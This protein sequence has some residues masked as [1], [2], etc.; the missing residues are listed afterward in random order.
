MKPTRN[1][2]WLVSI[3]MAISGTQIGGTYHIFLAYSL[4]RCND[5]GIPI[6]HWSQIK[7]NFG[8][9]HVNESKRT[10][11]FSRNGKLIEMETRP[12]TGLST[13]KKELKLGKA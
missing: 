13:E 12:K 7:T 9:N 11:F 2:I 8:S 4:G 5:P 6:E 3:S 10:K 1:V